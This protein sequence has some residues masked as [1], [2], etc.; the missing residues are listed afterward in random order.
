MEESAGQSFPDNGRQIRETV[1][2][3]G[4]ENCRVTQFCRCVTKCISSSHVSQISGCR[5]KDPLRVSNQETNDCAKV[6]LDRTVR[7]ELDIQIN[8]STF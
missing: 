2:F 1:P 7:E 5:R 8:Q 3:W 6:Q 4:L